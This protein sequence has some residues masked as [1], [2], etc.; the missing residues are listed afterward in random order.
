MHR[1][2]GLLH[3]E[4]QAAGPRQAAGFLHGAGTGRSS[5]WEPEVR[6]W[7][8]DVRTSPP[9]ADGPSA[10]SALRRVTPPDS[11]P[12]VAPTLPGRVR[13]PAGPSVAPRGL[14]CGTAAHVLRWG[15]RSP[16][17]MPAFLC[18]WSRLTGLSEIEV[19]G[20]WQVDVS[21]FA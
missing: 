19:G 9:G 20:V 8:E 11:W 3:G 15:L 16:G 2:L 21:E 17:R 4:G 14:L 10:L 7:P 18:T 13:Q 12:P 1:A 5:D 6:T